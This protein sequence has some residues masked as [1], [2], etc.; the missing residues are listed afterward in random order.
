MISF[1]C[2]NFNHKPEFTLILAFFSK[3][4]DVF[5]GKDLGSFKPRD[6]FN[7]IVNP[8]GILVV[9]FSI[10]SNNKYVS[11]GADDAANSEV[12]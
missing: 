5:T 12:K 7:G 11:H 1:L 6:I 9:K 3:A 2:F 8:T 4:S 10:L